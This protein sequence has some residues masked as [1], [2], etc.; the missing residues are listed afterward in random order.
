MS[1]SRDVVG[2]LAVDGA[3]GSS[4][5]RV[6]RSAPGRAGVR[7]HWLHSSRNL[8]SIVIRLRGAVVHRAE[9]AGAVAPTHEVLRSWSVT[10]GSTSQRSIRVPFMRRSSRM[11]CV[12]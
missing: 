7:G 1:S 10:E 8:F 5:L 2:H 3:D 9:N 12:L 11:T 4:Q 6:A